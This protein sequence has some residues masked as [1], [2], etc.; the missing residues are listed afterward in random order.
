MKFAF[1][2]QVVLDLHLR[3]LGASITRHLRANYEYTPP[4]PY[5][6]FETGKEVMSG[7]ALK[8]DLE[9]L[10]RPRAEKPTKAKT[11]EPYWTSASDLLALGVLNRRVYKQ[12]N[13]MIDSDAQF[14]DWLRRGG[15]GPGAPSLPNAL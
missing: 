5:F 4:W 11:G 2:G 1:A 3:L 15:A 8:L 13:A 12:L 14:E 6:D 9:I 7:A 10:A